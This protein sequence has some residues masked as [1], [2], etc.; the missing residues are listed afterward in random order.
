MWPFSKKHS[1]P[2]LDLPPITIEAAEAF[3]LRQRHL[4]GF[5]LAIF[6]PIHPGDDLTETL[7]ACI[8]RGEPYR[9]GDKER[10]VTRDFVYYFM[11]ESGKQSLEEMVYK[12]VV[13]MDANT[14]E[15]FYGG[16][17]ILKFHDPQLTR[18]GDKSNVHNPRL[19]EVDGRKLVGT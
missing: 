7:A 8:V 9:K 11:N 1:Q 3:L 2:K 4:L 6:G 18:Q 14:L 15:I 13:D 10:N 16:K 17:P 12:N 19:V 5:R